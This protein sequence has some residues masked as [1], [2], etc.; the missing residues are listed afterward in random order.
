MIT[1]LPRRRS[2]YIKV[3]LLI[4]AS[5]VLVTLLFTLSDN[6]SNH[7]RSRSSHVVVVDA[8]VPAAAEPDAGNTFNTGHHERRP[9]VEG[10]NKKK[11]KT[12]ISEDQ[13]DSDL[14]PSAQRLRQEL[15]SA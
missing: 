11:E 4:P 8:V 14:S 5:W 1:F 15:D 13:E 9:H 3:L 2:L 10:S 6:S 7:E 12:K